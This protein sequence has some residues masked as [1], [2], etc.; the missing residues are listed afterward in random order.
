[1]IRVSG[2]VAD[3]E[4]V[5]ARRLRLLARCPKDLASSEFRERAVAV[6]DLFLRELVE[7]DDALGGAVEIAAHDLDG[8][9]TR[10]CAGMPRL[11]AER[12]AER[13]FG[14][15]I[16]TGAIGRASVPNFCAHASGQDLLYAS[17]RLR[18]AFVVSELEVRD[19]EREIRVRRRAVDLLHPL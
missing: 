9:Q 17:E 18:R 3:G 12:F 11:R 4:L 15:A 6:R 10:A 5:R 8:R 16:A 1:E 2:I 13:G 14:R 19:R 7:L